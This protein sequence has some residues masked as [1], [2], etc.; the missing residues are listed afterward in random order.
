VKT[1]VLHRHKNAGFSL[2]ELVVVIGIIGILLSIGTINFNQWMVKN[3]VEAQVRQMVTDFSE[4]RVKAFTTKQRHSITVN[5]TSYS[6]KS[7]SSEAEDKCTGGTVI[8]GKSTN[9]NFKL[10]EDDTTY[11]S[12][13]CQNV[14]GDTFEIDSRGMLLGSTG[15]VFLEYTNASPAIDCFK[16]HTLRINPGKKNGS[17]CDDK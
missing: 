8:P 9:V 5:Q 2:I 3:R 11:Y 1:G 15:T 14:A 12:G 16:I 10:K 13:S 4:I 17:A 6:F 7:Y